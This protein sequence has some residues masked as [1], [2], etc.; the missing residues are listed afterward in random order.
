VC[1]T[2]FFWDFLAA[3]FLA[4][5][6]LAAFFGVFFAAFFAA[7][8]FFVADIKTVYRTLKSKSYCQKRCC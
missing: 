7:G 8:F 2:A 3:G 6:F 1:L 4:A 5:G